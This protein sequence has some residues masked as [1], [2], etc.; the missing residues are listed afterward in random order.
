[1]QYSGGVP[2]II[3]TTTK[4]TG[5]G[6]QSCEMLVKASTK[7][8][9]SAAREEVLFDRTQKYCYVL[10]P[11]LL[12]G[13]PVDQA[14][15]QYDGNSSQWVV[16]VHFSSNEFV[17]RVAEPNLNRVVAIVLDDVV[18]TAPTINPGITG[19]DVQIS[20]H[21]SRSD[22]IAVAASIRGDSPSQVRVPSGDT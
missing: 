18:Q 19:R 9:A 12:T 1:V 22:A 2:L 21:Y 20:G 11:A 8:P 6:G 5:P 14:A 17:T 7:R 3:P 15:A 10:G 4:T 13:D 16:N